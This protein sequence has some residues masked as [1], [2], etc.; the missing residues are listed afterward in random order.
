MSADKF[1]NNLILLSLKYIEE[2]YPYVFVLIKEFTR[3]NI[4][5]EAGI[6]FESEVLDLY[7]L[8]SEGLKLKCYINNFTLTRLAFTLPLKVE[9]EQDFEEHRITLKSSFQLGVSFS[10][11][12]PKDISA[13]CYLGASYRYYD[14]V[15]GE[16]LGNFKMEYAKYIMIGKELFIAFVDTSISKE[17]NN[18]LN[19]LKGKGFEFDLNILTDFISSPECLEKIKEFILKFYTLDPSVKVYKFSWGS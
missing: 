15:G 14:A 5:K 2:L 4:P 7:S 3:R 11:E 12:A 10:L 6:W 9:L 19:N 13:D 1:T 16:S 17:I 18:I 8:N